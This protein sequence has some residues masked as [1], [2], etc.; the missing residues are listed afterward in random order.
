[1]YITYSSS[2]I[3]DAIN[4]L[5]DQSI[6]AGSSTLEAQKDGSFAV[7]I[8][9]AG[10]KATHLSLVTKQEAYTGEQYVEVVAENTKYGKKTH[11]VYGSR[12]VDFGSIKAKLA[13]GILSVTAGVRAEAQ[14]RKI[15]VEG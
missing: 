10:Y 1:M 5:L 3:S 15:T 8:E 2:S 7:E 6:L 11:K 14:P 13:D 4:S 9:A 12:A